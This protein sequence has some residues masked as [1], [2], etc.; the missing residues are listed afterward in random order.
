M[1]LI[2]C[3]GFAAA[4]NCAPVAICAQEVAERALPAPAGATRHLVVAALTPVTLEI[5][6]EQSSGASKAGD[7]FPLRLAEPIVVDGAVIVPAG[8]PG[9]GEV[10]HAKRSGGMGAA[11]ELILTASYFDF[12]ERRVKLRSLRLTGMGK[13]RVSTVDA[14]V[15]AS[16]ASPIPVGFI[17]FFIKGGQMVV[18]AG[19]LAEAKTAEPFEAAQPEFADRPQVEGEAP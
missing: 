13:D 1:R 17:G 6:A 14:L 10:V 4:L 5:L 19:T 11:G 12:G 7:R 15:V 9:E 2:A 16:A 8:A 3:A 18:P